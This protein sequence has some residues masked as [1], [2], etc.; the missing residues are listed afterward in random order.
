MLQDRFELFDVS[1][2]LICKCIQKIKTE[3][4]LPYGL[5]SSH[6]LFLVQL[7][8]SENGLTAAELSEVGHVDKAQISRVITEL[9][10]KGYVKRQSL[11]RGQK[12]KNKL[13]LTVTGRRVTKEIND[14]I[15]GILEYVSGSIPISDLE[16]FYRT[17]FTISNNLFSLTDEQ[18]SGLSEA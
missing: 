17:L 8:K 7:G 6:V 5:K 10:D 2:S 4:V 14:M 9:T 12:Y 11:Y 18:T 3:K 1:V 15:A 13:T 16:I